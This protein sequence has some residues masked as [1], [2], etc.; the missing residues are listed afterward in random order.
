MRKLLLYWYIQVG[1]IAFAAFATDQMVKMLM[2]EILNN[3]L[4]TESVQIINGLF[5]LQF[6]KNTGVAFS[7]P[8]PYTILI[9]ATIGLLIY[10][11]YLA[12]EYLDLKKLSTNLLVGMVVGGAAGNLLDRIARGFVTDYIAIWKWPVFN[13]ADIF[14][15]I[16]MFSIVIFYGKIGK[17]NKSSI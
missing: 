7:I 10:G 4:K 14:I 17:N 13:L 12:Q 15:T 1:I 3:L 5:A 2:N 16:G 8:I 6:E 9:P 11:L